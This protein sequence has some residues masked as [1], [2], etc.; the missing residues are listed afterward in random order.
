MKKTVIN[1][2][3]NKVQ[4]YIERA[5]TRRLLTD[6]ADAVYSDSSYVIYKDADE[7][8]Y[9]LADNSKDTPYEIGNVQELNEYLESEEV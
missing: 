7:D 8:I 4:R 3:G 6:K 1:K 2:L 5:N 9:Y